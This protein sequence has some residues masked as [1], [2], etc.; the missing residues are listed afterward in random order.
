MVSKQTN[1]QTHTQKNLLNIFKRHRMRL[2]TDYENLPCRPICDIC[3][4]LHVFYLSNLTLDVI[5]YMIFFSVIL[6]VLLDS[7]SIEP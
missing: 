3:S 5:C 7:E 4:H 6:F 1:K 2:R